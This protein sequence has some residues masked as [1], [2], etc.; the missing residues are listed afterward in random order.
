[1]AVSVLFLLGAASLALAL[2]AFVTYPLSL[3]ALKLWQRRR[4]P[5]PN[6]SRPLATQRVA[7]CTYASGVVDLSEA[8][9]HNLLAIAAARPQLQ[10]MVYVDGEAP[11]LLQRLEPHRVQIDVHTSPIRRGK[12]HGMNMLANRTRADLLVF[13]DAAVLLDEHLP[14]RLDT[15]FADRAVGCVCAAPEQRRLDGWIKGLESDT[16]STLGADGSLFAVRAA[17]YHPAPAH[18]P[19]AMYVS[20]MVLCGGHRV[21]CAAGLRARQDMVSRRILAIRS[22]RDLIGRAQRALHVHRLVRPMLWRLDALSVYK[23]V[24]HKL[25]RW[26]SVYLLTA[27]CGCFMV[28]AALSR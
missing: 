13:A 10:L 27:A 22:R 25:L 5:P 17:L 15:H 23:Y 3:L 9:L 28:A 12:S 2:H 8:K 16:G 26:C 4:P 19:H 14:A 6:W 24:S 21:V 20:L 1:M 7:L 18:A 11:E